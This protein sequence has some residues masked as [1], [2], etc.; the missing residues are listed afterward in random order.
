MKANFKRL[1]GLLTALLMITAALP[2]GALAEDATSSA[3]ISWS[4]AFDVVQDPAEPSTGYALK[5]GEEAAVGSFEIAADY[6]LTEADVY[7]PTGAEFAIK[8]TNGSTTA[9]ATAT[10]KGGTVHV[11]GDVAEQ[12]FG[13]YENDKWVN[14][15]LLQ[16]TQNGEYNVYVDNRAILL[17]E[18]QGTAGTPAAAEFAANDTAYVKN[19]KVSSY[20]PVENKIRNVYKNGEMT[21]APKKV[22]SVAV[23]DSYFFY[24][25]EDV[26]TAVENAKHIRIKFNAVQSWTGDA[27]RTAAFWVGLAE[28]SAVNTTT[29]NVRNASNGTMFKIV[30]DGK[31]QKGGT[32][33]QTMD[34]IGFSTKDNT[35]ADYVID[36]VADEENA[37]EATVTVRVGDEIAVRPFTCGSTVTLRD[38][39]NFVFQVD[40]NNTKSTFTFKDISV[41]VV[42]SASA[43]YFED[44]ESTNVGSDPAGFTKYSTKTDKNETFTVKS[45]AEIKSWTSTTDG[46]AVTGNSTNVAEFYQSQYTNTSTKRYLDGGTVEDTSVTVLT[47]GTAETV[48]L[49]LPEGLKGQDNLRLSFNLYNP[50]NS[51]ATTGVFTQKLRIGF[52]NEIQEISSDNLNGHF[53][54]VLSNHS[55]KTGVRKQQF[56]V[57]GSDAKLAFPALEWGNLTMETAKTYDGATATGYN[58]TAYGRDKTAT[59]TADDT[60]AMNY[61]VMQIPHDNGGK[62]YLDNILVEAVCDADEFVGTATVVAES[63]IAP[64]AYA[65]K[66]VTTD[67]DK[68]TA[69][70]IEKTG[71]L[72][73]AAQH[74]LYLAIYDE[75]KLQ[76]VA[77]TNLSQG[78]TG[79]EKTLTFDKS[80]SGGK[81]YRIFILDEKLTPMMAAYP[82][83]Q[84]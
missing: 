1:L 45:G 24:A 47:S 46:T 63:D 72:S 57:K 56:T 36:I 76:N 58:I 64:A 26:N 66:E 42:S 32:T 75:G 59:Q 12:G 38:C 11:A 40:T 15:K 73:P 60:G 71:T 6:V 77:V 44:F 61:L 14:V 20:T 48:Y 22:D 69:V 35:A 30:G 81:T 65:V 84:Q 43:V 23:V 3:A 7:V 55:E 27:S 51:I 70:T 80:L 10:L 82:Q 50:L 53:L 8:T 37:N 74:T 18:A 34:E 5:I 41:E 79:T 33:S 49:E 4:G 21:L 16:N 62:Y 9:L 29:P 28:D 78:F 68:I 67:S 13:T 52:A 54:F 39:R 31:V 2:C 25:G 19:V 83:P 17:L